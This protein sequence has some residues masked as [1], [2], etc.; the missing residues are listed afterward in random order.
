MYKEYGGQRDFEVK[1][2]RMP[3]EPTPASWMTLLGASR[4]QEDINKGKQVSK[5]IFEL[6]CGDASPYVALSNLYAIVGKMNDSESVV[7]S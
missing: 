3:C 4:I 7:N 5:H 1:I 2:K 6:D